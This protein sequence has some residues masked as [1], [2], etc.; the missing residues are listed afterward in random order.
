MGASVGNFPACDR[1]FH[2]PDEEICGS[3]APR[4][5]QCLR[6]CDEEFVPGRHASSSSQI[7]RPATPGAHSGRLG[8]LPWPP[9][10]TPPRNAPAD[11]HVTWSPNVESASRDSY[12]L[13]TPT[14]A[15]K[16]SHVSK[17]PSAAACPKNRTP[18][19]KEVP[20]EEL[21][22]VKAWAKEASEQQET[23]MARRAS[24]EVVS[25]RFSSSW[26]P[27]SIR[28]LSPERDDSE[29][30]ASTKPSSSSGA[31]LVEVSDTVGHPPVS[32]GEASKE[33]ASGQVPSKS[34]SPFV[35]EAESALGQLPSSPS[36][37]LAVEC[38]STRKQLFQSPIDESG[39]NPGAMSAEPSADSGRAA[40]F[41]TDAASVPPTGSC[42]EAI[43]PDNMKPPATVSTAAFGPPAGSCC[44]AIPP[45][46]TKPPATVSDAAFGPPTGSCSEAIRPATTKPPATISDAALWP[47]TGIC[48]EAIAP[49]TTKPPA[50]ISAEIIASSQGSVREL[51]ELFETKGDE[52]MQRQLPQ[53]PDETFASEAG[54]LASRTHGMSQKQSASFKRDDL[55]IEA[56]CSFGQSPPAC[57]S[58]ALEQ[59]AIPNRD[60]L[61]IET[62]CLD[63][64]QH[65]VRLDN[66]QLLDSGCSSDR[67]D[68]ALSFQADVSK[69]CLRL[70]MRV[71]RSRPRPPSSSRPPGSRPIS[72]SAA[73]V[74]KTVAFDVP[75]LREEIP[76]KKSIAWVFE[77]ARNY[78]ENTPVDKKGWSC[79]VPPVLESNA[80][81]LL[82]F[83]ANRPCLKLNATQLLSIQA[84]EP[85]RDS[86][87]PW[88]NKPSIQTWYLPHLATADEATGL[89]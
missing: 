27:E 78:T 37:S 14:S 25:R 28:S 26:F 65:Q 58:E 77:N 75:G 9:A 57:R 48:S 76:T 10:S 30:P 88:W 61:C 66:A 39:F 4:L 73:A 31:L 64:P 36:E 79:H 18:E 67:L 50:M 47:P 55:C 8:G 33:E 35:V 49:G 24:K 84:S 54:G 56:E 68:A 29:N 23:L 72:P 1:S 46:T 82:P 15:E 13:R 89:Q 34:S 22:P 20:F 3:S 32:P 42:S 83:Q 6:G 45:D 59:S 41:N 44:E 7:L 2:V 63:R 70:V 60:D 38:A 40:S 17:A 81:R 85:R 80:S 12:G 69:Y 19:R 53:I 86:V 21:P 74:V 16:S 62:E 5:K 87:I 43:L 51:R 71:V 52:G 11:L